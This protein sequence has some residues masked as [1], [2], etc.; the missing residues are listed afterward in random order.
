M[1]LNN[2]TEPSTPIPQ[3]PPSPLPQLTLVMRT[4][5]LH[6]IRVVVEEGVDDAS[7]PEL[8]LPRNEGEPVLVVVPRRGIPG[9]YQRHHTHHLV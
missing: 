4:S 7:V 5:S 6:E 1:N 8:L 9:R 3:P 2:K